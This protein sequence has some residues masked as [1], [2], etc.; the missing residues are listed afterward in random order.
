MS[1]NGSFQTSDQYVQYMF[2][3]HVLKI[4]EIVECIQ[5]HLQPITELSCVMSDHLIVKFYLKI[6][7]TYIEIEYSGI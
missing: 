7:E 6:N 4:L 5:Q 2:E 3:N 1:R